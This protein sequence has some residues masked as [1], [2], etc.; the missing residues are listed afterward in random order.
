MGSRDGELTTNS[1][2]TLYT[3]LASQKTTEAMPGK[4]EVH[5]SNAAISLLEIYP[6]VILAQMSLYKTVHCSFVCNNKD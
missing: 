6:S 1:S 2:T 5:I 4:L 3:I